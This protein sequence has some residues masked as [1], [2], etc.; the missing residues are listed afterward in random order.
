MH[1]VPVCCNT[2]LYPGIQINFMDDIYGYE[3]VFLIA[4]V[5][6]PT[7]MDTFYYM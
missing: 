4:E 6:I 2:V 5:C 3:N 1:V 7:V